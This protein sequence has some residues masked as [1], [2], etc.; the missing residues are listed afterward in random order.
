[1]LQSDINVFENQFPRF[2]FDMSNRLICDIE[3]A[4]R[5]KI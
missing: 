3:Y 5:Y 4:L 1:M 2:T